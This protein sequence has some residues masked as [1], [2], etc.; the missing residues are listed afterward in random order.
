MKDG[1]TAQEVARLAGFETTLMLNY[2]ERSGT[3]HRQ[4]GGP[5]HHGK[6]RR[7]TFRD[8]VV[9]RAINRLLSVGARP[10]RIQ[11]AI[12][13]F[14][15]IGPMPED[16]DALVEFAKKASLFVVTAEASYSASRSTWWISA[17]A[18]SWPFPS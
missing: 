8:L 7:Y 10:K 12:E 15:R 4:L 6:W 2:L 1:F 5:A 11:Q 13:T 9:L 14:A 3:F 16:A 17:P 18:A